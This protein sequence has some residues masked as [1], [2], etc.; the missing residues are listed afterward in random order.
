LGKVTSIVR[1]SRPEPPESL[2][3]VDDFA[4]DHDGLG[5]WVRKNFID[6]EGPLHNPRHAHLAN[7]SI[8]W[9][10]TSA[11]AKNKN[12]EIAGQC[13]LVQPQQKTFSSAMRSWQLRQWFGGVPDFVIIISRWFAL[14]M[15]DYSFCALIEHELCHAAQDVDGFGMPKFDREGQPMFRIVAHDVE[16]FHDVVE[17]YGAKA[18][19]VSRMVKLGN[20]PPSIGEAKMSVACG[21]CKQMVRA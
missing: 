14:D 3:L 16:E 6:P 20:Q 1:S 13:Q 11:T 15:D 10:W 5:A 12:R 8:G 4:P 17:R 21:T 2:G 18:A 7:A 9:L 19:G